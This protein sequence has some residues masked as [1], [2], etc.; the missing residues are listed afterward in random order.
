MSMPLTVRM[1]RWWGHRQ[2]LPLGL[3]YRLVRKLADPERMASLA[4]ECDFAGLRY[5][6][7]LDSYIDWSVYFLGAYEPEALT[8]LADRA[9]AAGPGAVFV[10]IGANVGQH[11]LYMAPHVARV[12]AFEPWERARTAFLDNIARNRLNNVVVH[13]V[14]LGERDEV[15]PFHVPATSNLGTGSFVAGLND[16][17]A[18]ESL[19]VRRGDDM[20]ADLDR[21]DVVKIDTEGFELQVLRGLAETLARHRPVVMFELND[22]MVATLGGADVFARSLDMLMG[23]GWRFH[24][25]LAKGAG[26]RLAPLVHDGGH[27]V[28]VAVPD[29]I[30]RR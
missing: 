1:L 7:R 21:V 12:V 8:F 24:R 6:G 17:V 16:N 28:A 14:A 29:N 20:L 18:G 27:A 19:P 23:G 5:G 11:S 2:W 26:Y 3:R 13:P 30:E 9:A 15:L 25:L 22:V 4:F 10:D